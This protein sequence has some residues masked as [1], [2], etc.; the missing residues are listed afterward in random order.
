MRRATYDELLGIAKAA[1]RSSDAED[2]LHDALIA[3]MA[4]GRED[5][6]KRDNRVWLYGTIR[7]LGRMAARGH[8]RRRVRETHWSESRTVAPP[9]PPFVMSTFLQG[10]P[11]ATKAIAALVL[12]SHNRRE[13]AWL[14][15]L[16]D[17]ALRQRMTALRRSLRARGLEMPTGPAGLNLD[18]SYGRI[19]DVLLP[20]LLRENGEFASHDPDGH[21]FVVRRSQ[22]R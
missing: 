11:P 17:T 3:A 2:L 6:T 9:A 19:R 15:R 14:L 21:L 16:T 8:G 13:I 1:S 7:N 5:M 20:A 4:C 22:S 18:I 12:T 10:L